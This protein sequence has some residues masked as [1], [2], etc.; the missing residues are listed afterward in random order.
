MTANPEIAVTLSEEL[1]ERLRA[2]ARQL[3][4]PLRWLVAGLVC[5]TIEPNPRGIGDQPQGPTRHVA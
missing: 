3:H 4:V 2:Q 1:L 5:D